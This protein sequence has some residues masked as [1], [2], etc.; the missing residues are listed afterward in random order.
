MSR[1]ARERWRIAALWFCLGVFILRVFGQIEV[2]L[3]Q[4]NFLPSFNAWESGLVPYALLLP[5]QILLIAWMASIAVEHT[6]GEGFFWVEAPGPR[7]RLRVFASL[8]AAA[9]AVRLAVTAMIPPHTVL[10]RGLIP[11][12]AHWDLATFMALVSLAPAPADAEYE[13]SIAV[14]SIPRIEV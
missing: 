7:R 11:I 2:L 10:N 4:P 3:L 8:Y 14:D 1:S 5:I 13:T 6:R 9:M 12:V